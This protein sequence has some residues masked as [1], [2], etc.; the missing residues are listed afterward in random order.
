MLSSFGPLSY[1]AYQYFDFELPGESI[2]DTIIYIFVMVMAFT[3]FVF[4]Y[5][6]KALFCREQ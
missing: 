2:F 4:F 1:L 5:N 6:D 3:E